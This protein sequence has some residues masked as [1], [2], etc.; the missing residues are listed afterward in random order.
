M[1]DKSLSEGQNFVR[2]G[3]IFVAINGPGGPLLMLY[4]VRVH[5]PRLLKH[6]W[7]CVLC[8]ALDF[9]AYFMAVA[10]FPYSTKFYILL[11]MWGLGMWLCR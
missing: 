10:T 9:L 8:L 11:I 7:A 3:T 6:R 2:G 5:E 1:R 4:F